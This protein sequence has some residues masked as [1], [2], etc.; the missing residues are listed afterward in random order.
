M[1]SAP[2]WFV[3][4]LVSG[5]TDKPNRKGRREIRVSEIQNLKL[6]HPLPEIIP[7]RS[8]HQLFQLAALLA[9][10]ASPLASQTPAKN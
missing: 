9:T 5:L 2:L 1:P 6:T 4:K 8:E 10:N 7:P 3:K